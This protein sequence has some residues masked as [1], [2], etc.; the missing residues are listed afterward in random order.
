LLELLKAG[1]SRYRER[2]R[3]R[4][5]ENFHAA[6]AKTQEEKRLTKAVP[7]LFKNQGLYRSSE[8]ELAPMITH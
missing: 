8:K 7:A 3:T 2:I 4:N 1:R 5:A 6:L